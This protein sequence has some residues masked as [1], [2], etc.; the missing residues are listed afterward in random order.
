MGIQNRLILQFKA[1]LIEMKN[2]IIYLICIVLTPSISIFSQEAQDHNLTQI[3]GSLAITNNG[4]S[5]VPSFS[6]EKPASVFNMSI[7]KE[8]FSFDPELAFSLEAKP[9][10]SLFWFRYNL[11]PNQSKFKMNVGTHLGLNFVSMH[12]PTTKDTI[13]IQKTD[14]YLVLELFPRY[15]VSQHLTI[16]VYYLR[17]HGLND[18]T[19]NALNFVTLYT[20]ISQIRLNKSTTLGITPQF[21]YLNIDG[22]DGY[23]LTSEISLLIK[24]FPIIFK[25]TMNKTFES[26]VEGSKPF[27]WNIKLVYPL[28]AGKIKL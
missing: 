25:S 13:Q 23:Y 22:K 21:Y 11:S 1:N 16:G 7:S 17:S 5:I 27:L 18:G 19:L 24:D 14:R 28:K 4:I 10:Y 3:N 20:D 8:R 9:W 6:L 26:K 15:Q 2:A 12:I